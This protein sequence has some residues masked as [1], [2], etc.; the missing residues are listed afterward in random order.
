MN[1]KPLDPCEA[2]Q[3][4]KGRILAVMVQAS[5]PMNYKPLDPCEEQ[6]RN[7]EVAV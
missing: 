2:D 1:Y 6:I 4:S 3:K 7:K 5:V